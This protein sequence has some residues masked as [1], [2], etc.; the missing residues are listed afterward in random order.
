[1]KRPR[2][3]STRK[4]PLRRAGS[5]RSDQPRFAGLARICGAFAAAIATLFLR[6]DLGAQESPRIEPGLLATF[7]SGGTSDVTV[8]QN[9]LLYV[10]AGRPPTPFLPP[11]KFSVTWEGFVSVDLRDSYTFSA[12]LNGSLKLEVNSNAVFEA[13]SGGKATGPG[14]RVRLNKG[15]NTL[16]VA[17]TAP[18]KGDAFL[19]LYWS[20]PDFGPEPI[21]IT[22][23]S[24]APGS[25]DGQKG[26]LLRRGRE[27]F[28]ELRCAKCHA[29]DGAALPELAMDAPSFEGIGSRRHSAW[30]ADWILDPHKQRATAHMPKLL[31]GP[32]AE[33][34]AAAIAAF[35][36]SL[37]DAA[38]EDHAGPNT[39]WA[40]T[41]RD[42]AEKLHCVACHNLPGA[43]EQDAN[44]ISLAHVNR[45]FPPAALAAFLKNPG[46]QFAWTRMPDFKL[47]DDEALKLAAFLGGDA[48]T[49]R[50]AAA[51]TDA[52]VIARGQRLVQTTGCLNCHTLRLENQFQAP[53]VDRWRNRH[54]EDRA[55]PVKGDCLG[56][57]P[58][59]DYGLSK[60]DREA[61][62]AFTLAGFDSL[63]RHVPAEFAERLSRAMNCAGCH[64][65]FE[66]FPPF[67]ILGAK[68]KPE[69]TRALLAGEVSYKPR[70]WLEARMPAFP[71]YAEA[72]AQGL[73]MQHGLPPQ[74]PAE[75]PVNTE[76][77]K[78]GHAM[79]S[80]DG[81]FSCVACHAV[82]SFGA[83]QVFEAAGLNFQHASER[84]QPSYF[85]RWMLNPLR[86]DPQTKM[87]VY[88]NQ[89][90]SPLT[91]HFNGDAHLQIDALWQYLRLGDKMPL[92]KEA[93]PN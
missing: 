9:A 83:T 78:A 55:K 7:L 40:S 15:A 72:L 93:N 29:A 71:K 62:E 17:F 50:Q 42:L 90:Q 14:K 39:D 12:E 53:P 46:A 65:K 16:K 48:P 21:P 30:M 37:K 68:L 81:G 41:G 20:S 76:A 58:V 82:R 43:K 52:A 66:G 25:A 70:H 18:D 31:H 36:A 75:P 92:P 60:E 32:K 63:A 67:P 47:K 11:G 79:I 34:E 51:S 28:I 23:L 8:M 44:K 22:A 91:D 26:R 59:A 38:G 19:R 74:T 77:A 45:K 13:A 87:P 84:L 3:D 4:L 80:T 86:I 33:E 5:R 2:V 56:S 24:H 61:L 54:L 85:R 64:G 1:M 49:A 73:A 57:A 88:F 89:G 35:L 27:L 6:A 69:W 10:P